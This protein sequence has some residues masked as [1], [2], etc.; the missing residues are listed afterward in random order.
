MDMEM[1]VQSR[2]SRSQCDRNR[3]ESQDVSPLVTGGRRDQGV[4]AGVDVPRSIGRNI[5]RLFSR[6]IFRFYTPVIITPAICG[7]SEDVTVVG[8]TVPT[9]PSCSLL[10]SQLLRS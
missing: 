4:H 1:L 6:M 9:R 8:L 10:A 5:Q 2:L 3:K 7:A